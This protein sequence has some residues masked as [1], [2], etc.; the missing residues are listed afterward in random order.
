M[1]SSIL[2]FKIYLAI[3]AVIFAIEY[4]IFLPMSPAAKFPTNFFEF[5]YMKPESMQKFVIYEK[6]KMYSKL[7]AEIVS[8]GDSS[9]LF[10]LQPAVVAQSLHGTNMINLNV[11]A[12][13]GFDGYRYILEYY[14]KRNKRAKYAVLYISPLQMP[15]IYGS[16]NKLG[17]MIY[18]NYVGVSRFLSF[19]NFSARLR[20]TNYFYYGKFIDLLY[21]FYQP[22]NGGYPSYD[23]WEK[24]LAV[25][26]GWLPFPKGVLLSPED[27]VAEEKVYG[28]CDLASAEG[29]HDMT[30]ESELE[31]FVRLTETL[32][33]KP[34]VFFNPVVCSVV[35]G[36][37]SDPIQAQL[38]S[39]SAKHPTV[40]IP[41]DL[42][43]TWPAAYFGDELHLAPGKSVE[44]S[45]RVGNALKSWIDGVGAGNY[46]RNSFSSTSLDRKSRIGGTVKSYDDGGRLSSERTYRDGKLDGVARTYYENGQVNS[47]RNYS[48]GKL[49]GACK[50]YFPNGLLEL[51]NYFQAGIQLRWSK[52]YGKNGRLKTIRYYSKGLREGSSVD[53]Y[54]NGKIQLRAQYHRGKLDGLLETYS[55]EG[56]KLSESSYRKG[57]LQGKVK[58]YY[59][60]GRLKQESNYDKDD[61]VGLKRGFYES[62]AL[63]QEIEFRR[64]SPRYVAKTFFDNGHLAFED[65]FEY[66][67]CV[68]R[69][70]FD[71]SGYLVRIEK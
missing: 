36:A 51:E 65:I 47:E 5:A 29:R 17:R 66:G 3:A 44:E 60:N 22:M 2:R 38:D 31:K 27:S 61:P 68:E 63:Y 58:E 4:W 48:R 45:H 8:V 25:S 16:R 71:K 56:V 23:D 19:P 39:F 46:D 49:D 1:I 62:G 24:Q 43:T 21:N 33:M 18:K 54:E 37:G 13:T 69:R 15:I 26:R 12:D 20:V 9:G 30:F 41:W 50:K 70:L 32:G 7:D 64:N 59:Q 34:A 67:K 53:F 35:T 6:N 55:V 28:D 57:F 10:G 14:A 40:Y 11:A 42:I 52:Q